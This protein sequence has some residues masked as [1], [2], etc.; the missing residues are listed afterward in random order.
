MYT[1]IEKQILALRFPTPF[2][3]NPEFLVYMTDIVEKTLGTKREEFSVKKEEDGRIKMY[4]RQ[5]NF[6]NISVMPSKDIIKIKTF[7]EQKTG[8][9]KAEDIILENHNEA[10][11][12]KKATA[13]TIME[14]EKDSYKIAVYEEN[15]FFSPLGVL[16]KT[17]SVLYQNIIPPAG[18]ELERV[19]FGSLITLARIANKKII[20]SK[21]ITRITDVPTACRVVNLIDSNGELKEIQNQI[22]SLKSDHGFS[23]LRPD[24]SK[25]VEDIKDKEKLKMFFSLNSYLTSEKYIKKFINQTENIR[26]RDLLLREYDAYIN[27]KMQSSQIK[28]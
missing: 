11:I 3:K 15:M 6:V 16:N 21:V 10:L 7:K 12:V 27:E 17:E 8:E 25:C 22:F 24:T 4:D 26:T 5:G 2:V 18:S 20:N 1:E 13:D 9:K 19:Y 28:M 23:K 14:K